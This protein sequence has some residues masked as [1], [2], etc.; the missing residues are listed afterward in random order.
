[1]MTLAPRAPLSWLSPPTRDESQRTRPQLR[2]R[3]IAL[4]IE[5]MGDLELLGLLV[6]RGQPEEPLERRVERLW[7]EAGGLAGLSTRGVGALA[8]EL[9]LG[10]ACAARIA[11]GIELGARVARA[12]RAK[13]ASATCADEVIAWGRAR[14]IDLGHEE[15]WALLLDG[16]NRIVGERLVARGGL[17]ACALTA[18]DVL[19]PVVREAIGAFVL[20]HNH[21]GG[22]ACPSREDLRF[23]AAV[24]SAGLVLGI[25]LLDHVVVAR[26]GAVSLSEAGLMNAPELAGPDTLRERE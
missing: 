7:S 13:P 10:L 23:T 26:D 12:A 6:E 15:L 5:S 16:R 9:G 19:R 4:G 21:P 17:H 8:A 1:M 14:L 18:R 22:D 2:E 11:A 20:V 25:T 3:A 24:A